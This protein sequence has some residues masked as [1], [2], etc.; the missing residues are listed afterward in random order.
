VGVQLKGD[1]KGKVRYA[2][3]DEGE[4]RTMARLDNDGTHE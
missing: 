2:L 4:V 3:G 1:K